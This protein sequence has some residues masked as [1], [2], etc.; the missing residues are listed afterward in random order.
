MNETLRQLKDIKGPVAVPDHS[1]WILVAV[2]LAVLLVA[3]VFLWRYYAQKRLQPIRRRKDP[4]KEAI[5]KLKAIDY[6]GAKGAVYIFGE[7][8][9][10]LIEGDTELQARFEAL[11]KELAPYKYKKE[12]PKLA[13]EHIKAMKALV[14]KGSA[15]G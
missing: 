4:K 15:H 13:K 5:E 14:K 7:Y 9:P 2:V 3:A 6:T 10:R 1:L 8:L 11:E 12:V